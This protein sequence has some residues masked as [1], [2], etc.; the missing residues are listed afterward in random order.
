[1]TPEYSNPFQHPLFVSPGVSQ[2]LP[3]TPNDSN[4]R[5]LLTKFTHEVYSPT[6]LLR[7]ARRRNEVA[8]ESLRDRVE[9]AVEASKAQGV[10]SVSTV[11]V[12][13]Q[14]IPIL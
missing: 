2:C 7:K 3:S 13:L 14:L 8:F 10:A 5:S 11:T 6:T 12:G 9:V 4:S 1:M